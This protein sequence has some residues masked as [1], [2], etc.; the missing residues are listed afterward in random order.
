MK[1][2]IYDRARMPVRLSHTILYQTY[3]YN[4][5]KWK[6]LRLESHLTDFSIKFCALPPFRADCQ[7]TSCGNYIQIFTK[8]QEIS[9]KKHKFYK[10]L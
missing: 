10:F 3:K 1:K 2:I 9:L 7:E 4:I 5:K 8:K 6:C